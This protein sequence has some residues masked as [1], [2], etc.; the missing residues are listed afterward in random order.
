MGKILLLSRTFPPPDGGAHRRYANLCRSF[1]EGS[2]EVCT[3]RREG[4]EDF[5][6]GERYPIHRMPV[7]PH[8]ERRPLGFLRWTRWTL[9]RLRRGDVG[10]IW[11][12]DLHS[13]GRM[14]LLAKRLTGVPYGPSFYGELYRPEGRLWMRHVAPR[15][16]D[17]ASFFLANS[18]HIGERARDYAARIGARPPGGRLRAVPSG[19]DLDR[20]RPGKSR[21]WARAELGIEGDPLVLTVARII[22]QKGVDDAL[23]AFALIATELPSAPYA[24]AGSGPLEP[25]LRAL[26]AELGLVKRV[27]FLGR[28]PYELMPIVHAAADVHLLASRP[29]PLWN[30][31]FPNACLEAMAT[32]V[33]VV[34]GAVGGVPEMVKDGETGF[35]VD[36]K[37]P[38][39]IADVVLRL[40][41]DPALR[42]S[43]GTAGRARAERELDHERAARDIYT[44]FAE[45]S[46]LPLPPWQPRSSAGPAA[47]APP[48]GEAPVHEKAPLSRDRAPATPAETAH[49]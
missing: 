18:A 33:P 48:S 16:F 23:R 35:L 17:E 45:C 24:I 6:R 9:R 19:V 34:A 40:L 41:R 4:A 21:A 25:E 27:R 15:V 12:G 8:G 13:T 1:P 36:P 30:E 49:A 37:D 32:G 22:P 38:R 3:S 43:M 46:R 39:A 31:N 29:V 5:D 10:V 42:A 28:V 14:A 44:V 11:V 2:I 7:A 26:S 20:F 47:D